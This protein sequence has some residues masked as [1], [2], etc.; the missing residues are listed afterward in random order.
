[1]GRWWARV[2]AAVALIAMFGAGAY[3]I[4]ADDTAPDGY[5]MLAI[6]ILLAGVWLA[7]ELH[8]RW[9]DHDHGGRG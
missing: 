9:S 6:S 5:A 1:M 8:D 3:R 4:E 2:P 7:T